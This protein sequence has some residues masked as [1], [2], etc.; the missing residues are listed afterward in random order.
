MYVYKHEKVSKELLLYA[1]Y[2][3]SMNIIIMELFMND[4]EIRVE[5]YCRV[6]YVYYQTF[7]IYHVVKSGQL[8]QLLGSLFGI[9]NC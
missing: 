5:I 4:N 2:L 3:C 9:S 8:R 7:F 6:A 1:H